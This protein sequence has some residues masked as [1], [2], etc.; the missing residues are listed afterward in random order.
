[1]PD[2]SGQVSEQEKAALAKRRGQAAAQIADP[3]EKKKF[4]SAQGDAEAS[5]KGDL[6]VS[7]YEGLSTGAALKG[8]KKGTD[9]VP[10]TGPAILHK[11]EAVLKK[12]D[13]E[14]YR[15][16]LGLSKMAGKDAEAKPS[17]KV[18]EVRIRKGSEGGY[19][20]ENHH[21]NPMEH[22]MTEHPYENQDAMLDHVME[23]MGEPNDGEEEGAGA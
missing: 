10:K 17:K 8:Y 19:I 4:I 15:K 5:N 20:V 18:K 9:N 12:S 2:T 7:K 11:G 21:E 16:V 6:S 23:H 1:M 14:Q 13:A 22:P 3:E